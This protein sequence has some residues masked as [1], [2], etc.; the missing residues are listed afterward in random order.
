MRWR[1]PLV[2]ILVLFVAVSCDQQ[3]VEPVEQPVATAPQF[4]FS[5]GPRESGVVVRDDY[6]ESYIIDMFWET[7]A[8]PWI[9]WMGLEPGEAPSFCVGDEKRPNAETLQV[10]AQQ[11]EK[12]IQ[13]WKKDKVPVTVFDLQEHYDYFMEGL[14]LGEDPYC[15]AVMNATPIGGGEG[16]Y[17]E[18]ITPANG[19][20]GW[21]AHFN[22]MVDYMGETYRLQWKIKNINSDNPHHVARVH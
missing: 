6:W 17:R 21:T 4:N 3:P 8:D 11:G 1:I 13:V 19:A 14:G 20:D 22:G 5:N 7:P 12:L 2:L 15:Y 18:T 10:A 9:L 16:T